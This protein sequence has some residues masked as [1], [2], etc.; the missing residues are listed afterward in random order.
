MRLKYEPSSEPLHISAKY[1]LD[2]AETA[3]ERARRLGRHPPPLPQGLHPP[4]LLGFRVQGSGFG[5]WGLGVRVQG[6]GFR[7]YG[8]GFRVGGVGCRV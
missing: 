1:L 2:F 8:A 5:V 6:S 3:L 4:P 7:V